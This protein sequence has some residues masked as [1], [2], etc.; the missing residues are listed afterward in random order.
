MEL[1]NHKVESFVRGSIICACTERYLSKIQ[2]ILVPKARRFFWPRGLETRWALE[3]AIARCQ[4]FLTSGWG[5][6]E[7]IKLMSLHMLLNDFW[8]PLGG[9][10]SSLSSPQRVASFRYVW[11]IMKTT[12]RLSLVCSTWIHWKFHWVPEQGSCFADVTNW[13]EN[14]WCWLLLISLRVIHLRKGF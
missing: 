7:V 1:T 8:V 6:A 14:L 10:F 9:K 5:Y 13:G 2:H 4:K 3:L 12:L 11:K